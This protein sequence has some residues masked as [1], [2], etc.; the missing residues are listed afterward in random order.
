[1][2][3][4]KSSLLRLCAALSFR[5]RPA[6]S[7]TG[8]LRVEEAVSAAEAGGAEEMTSRPCRAWK[9]SPDGTV[10]TKELLGN[11]RLQ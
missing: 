5:L 6:L 9:L 4:R 10:M 3:S 1:M 11:V 7:E 2:L 8:R